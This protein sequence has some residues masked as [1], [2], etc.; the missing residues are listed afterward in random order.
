V[1]ARYGLKS[2]RVQ[3]R[4]DHSSRLPQ[5]SCVERSELLLL[6][7][8]VEEW[9][10]HFIYMKY[11]S[12]ALFI[13]AGRCMRRWVI[14]IKCSATRA[15]AYLF[16]L[17]YSFSLCAYGAADC[18]L[19]EI[20]IKSFVRCRIHRD[21]L[22]HCSANHF[23][24]GI[25]FLSKTNHLARRLCAPRTT[26]PPRSLHT[27]KRVKLY[28]RAFKISVSNLVYMWDARVINRVTYGATSILS[29]NG[30]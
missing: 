6:C 5:F 18:S 27:F 1:S 9:I 28:I 20:Y 3:S 16:I 25:Y 21:H 26:R 10:L 22:S 13:L 23:D 19:S 30:N 12:P 4:V 15:C 11:L 8:D 14:D 7:R 2:Q 17:Y 24:V 29:H